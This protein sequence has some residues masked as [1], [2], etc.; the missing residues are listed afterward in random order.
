MSA[1]MITQPCT[2]FAKYEI[3]YLFLM[4]I[5]TRNT[6]VFNSIFAFSNH[7]LGVEVLYYP[8]IINKLP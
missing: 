2:I 7:L 1:V 5:I 4:I 3:Q 6:N 8:L